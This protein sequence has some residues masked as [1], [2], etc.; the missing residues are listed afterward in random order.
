MWELDSVYT[1]KIFRDEMFIFGD[2][3]MAPFTP[4]AFIFILFMQLTE[5]KLLYSGYSNL[6]WRS[7]KQWQWPLDHNNHC[8]FEQARL[9]LE[10]YFCDQ[11][12]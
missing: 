6:D 2:F 8:P 5:L 3:L 9:F 1:Q 10:M 7:R 12:L 4:F 11:M